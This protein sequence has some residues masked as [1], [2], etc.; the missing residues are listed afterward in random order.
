M[1]YIYIYIIRRANLPCRDV[2]LPRLS[3]RNP[4]IGRTGP[5]D[6]SIRADTPRGP[7]SRV[8]NSS[9]RMRVLRGH[10]LQGGSG[11]P[12]RL[13]SFFLVFTYFILNFLCVI[14]NR[15]KMLI[16]LLLLLFRAFQP[17]PQRQLTYASAGVSIPAGNLLV[18]RIKPLIKS[19]ARP[20]SDASIGGFG[21]VFD[22]RGAGYG[23]DGGSEN[24]NT[25]EDDTLLV[26]GTDGVG[27]KLKIAGLVGKHDSV[28]KYQNQ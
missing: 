1:I 26:S 19:T 4:H 12:V 28:G 15:V 25:K 8:P 3:S 17:T 7:R 6:I 13:F 9:E 18:E 22:L 20:G 27:T 16:L 5:R 14:I 10:V 24:G 21:G 23:G 11:L 2:A